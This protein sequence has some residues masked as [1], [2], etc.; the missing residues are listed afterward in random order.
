MKQSDFFKCIDENRSFLITSH[1]NPDGDSIGSMLALD[2]IIRS[3][4]RESRVCNTDGVPEKFSF[5]ENSD[6]FTPPPDSGAFDVLIIIDSSN[7]DRVGW[8]TGKIDVKSVINIDHHRDNSE[9]GDIN[10]VDPRASASCQILFQ[11]L[12]AEGIDMG[13]PLVDYLYTGILSD[14]G[15]FRFSNTTQDI[16]RVCADLMDHGVD[17]QKI[18]NSIYSS[19]S[20]NGLLLR[21]RIWS[22]LHFYASNTVACIEMPESAIEETGATYSDAEGMVDMLLTSKDVKIGVFMKYSDKEAHF[23]LRSSA[24]EN[25]VDVGRIA[26]S[27]PGG[28]GHTCAAGCTIPLPRNKAKHKI[29]Q[30]IEDELEKQT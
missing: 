21:A 18:Y 2:W 22:T 30:I 17:H 1:V 3:R 8:D 5:L 9:F 4:G 26:K 20:A 13:R 14:T 16:L 24:A 29:L 7:P 25:P 27:V 10:I 6:L 19:L 11:V 23:S 28:G 12:S 15:G